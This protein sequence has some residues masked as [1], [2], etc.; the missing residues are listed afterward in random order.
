M[1]RHLPA[2]VRI[3]RFFRAIVPAAGILVFGVLAVLGFLIYKISNPGSIPE[4]VN[5]SYYALP[6]L[7][8]VFSPEGG[9]EIPAWWIPGLKGAAGIVLAPGYGMNRSDALSLANVLHE[10]GFNIL[11]YSQRGSG[12]SPRGAST[13]GTSETGDMFGAIE[14]VQNRPESDRTRIGIWGVDVGAFAALNSAASVAE[15]RAVAVDGAFES[16]F[17]FLDLRVGEEAGLDNP[18]LQFGCRQMFRLVHFLSIPAMNEELPLQALSNRSILFIEGGNRKGLG[19]LTN[20]LY[21]KIQPQK[22][23]VLFTTSRVHM[24]RGEDTRNYDVQVANFFR[25]NLSEK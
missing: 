3:A 20:V 14:F 15:V 6:S 10:D 17:D 21:G 16:V 2:K 11:I 4:P 19:R 7:E 24:M 22:E 12:D 9:K 23:M 1:K 8:V 13:L 5:P 18:V 25:L